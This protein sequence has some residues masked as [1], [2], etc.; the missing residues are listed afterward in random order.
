M[1][2]MVVITPCLPQRPVYGDQS[3]EEGDVKVL[4]KLQIPVT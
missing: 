2:K 4:V 1:S 3:D